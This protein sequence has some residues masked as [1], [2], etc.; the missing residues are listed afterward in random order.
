MRR[1]ILILSLA[2]M[3]LSLYG[4][5]VRC[6]PGQ[7]GR[8]L[9][10]NSVTNLTVTGQMDARDLRTLA[11]QA[12]SVRTL[13]LSQVSIVAYSSDKP[14]FAN[15]HDYRAN[16]IPSLALANLSQLTTLRLPVTVTMIGEGAMAACT[17]LTTLTLPTSLYHLGA[18]SLAGCTA[19]TTVDLPASTGEIGDGAFNG[20]TALT[21][22]TMQGATPTNPSSPFVPASHELKRIGNRAFA[23]CKSLKSVNLGS[24]VQWIGDA[25]FAGTSL[26]QADLTQLLTLAHVGN[27]AYVQS[28]L[29]SV[30]LPAG[31]TDVGQG[32]FALNTQLSSFVPPRSLAQ[33]SP[34]LLAG[35]GL[36][37]E[38]SLG[39][40]AVDTIGAYALYNLNRVAQLTLPGTVQY[41]GTR[42]MAGMTGL[43][44]IT[45]RATQVPDL[46][47]DVWQGVDQGAV[48]LLTPYNS[49][50]YY[51]DA[52][53]WREFMIQSSVM[54]GDVNG[55]GVVD[56]A[57]QNAVLN[58]ILG[59][60]N[61]GTFNFDA[62]D[63]DGNGIIDI[64]DSNI[65]LNIILG[66]TLTTPVTVTANT[67][68]LLTAENFSIEA[69]ERHTIAFSLDNAQRYSGLQ[70]VVHLP[71][72]LTLV[73]GSVHAGAATVQVSTQSSGNDVRIVACSLPAAELATRAG[74]AVVC[75]TVEA[76]ER[77]S[78]ASVVVVDHV[79]MSTA[80]SE[81]YYA[82]ATSV[83]VSRTSGVSD[84]VQAVDRVYGANGTLHIVSS[85]ATT[86]RL[87]SLS[88]M[89]RHLEVAAGDNAYHHIDPGIYI[90][91]LNGHSHKVRL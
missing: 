61:S 73:E 20:C 72:G 11:D 69:G 8:L 44:R 5:E 36:L 19:L 31:L 90:I 89:T 86:A 57:D 28:Q 79:A 27:N 74:D 13:D 10:G 68:D 82:P 46:G 18:Y 32:A 9:A 26:T 85:Q 77:L 41:I 35:N 78:A 23:G 1:L 39:D 60:P 59:K 45:T 75:L 56:I 33:V 24:G 21:T 65:L 71:D 51:R 37:N 25:A 40:L 49:M 67:G 2:L 91:C 58:Y 42:A 30:A 64:A 70:C 47:E 12:R 17:C 6:L 80:D 83:Q 88:G 34:L 52:D 55:D 87:V 54:P 66:R 43:E 7:L 22:V 48:T 16:S 63:L 81:P 4:L 38:V 15:L 53:Q 84:A 29:T 3:Q 50:A 14:L 76:S 62:A